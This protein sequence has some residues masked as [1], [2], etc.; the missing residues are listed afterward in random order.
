MVYLSTP[1]T[2]SGGSPVLSTIFWT[3]ITIGTILVLHYLYW[4]IWVKELESKGYDEWVIQGVVNKFRSIFGLPARRT[5]VR[6]TRRERQAIVRDL[7][8]TF[9]EVQLL[10]LQR[11][12]R[13]ASPRINRRS[14]AEPDYHAMYW[15]HAPEPLTPP[16]LRTRNRAEIELL[17]AEEEV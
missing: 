13:A 12:A 16:G 4:R 2:S 7:D 3:F 15:P 6:Q 14:W 10:P 5:P 17:N 11:P 1:A 9:R 8:R